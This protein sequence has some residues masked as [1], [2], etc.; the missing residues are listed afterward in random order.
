MSI[1]L[2]IPA[3]SS[4]KLAKTSSLTVYK[5]LAIEKQKK[6]TEV[7]GRNGLRKNPFPL[8]K[9]RQRV[10]KLTYKEKTTDNGRELGEKRQHMDVGR[11]T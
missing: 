11:K 9:K 6:K 7:F 8:L 5:Q 2:S 4:L 10:R 1:D 3:K